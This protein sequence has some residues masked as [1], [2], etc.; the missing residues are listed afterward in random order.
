MTDRINGFTVILDREMRID[1]VEELFQAIRLI[2]G[3]QRVEPCII[4]ASDGLAMMKEKDRLH[5]RMQEAI[6]EV[7]SD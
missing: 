3:V 2:R 7:F 5:R 4:E 6:K 1:D